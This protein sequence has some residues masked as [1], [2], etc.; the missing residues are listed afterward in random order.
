MTEWT[1]SHHA[2]YEIRPC[3]A[4]ST[5]R[6]IRRSQLVL[7]YEVG[8]VF[9]QVRFVPANEDAHGGKRNSERQGA[10]RHREFHWS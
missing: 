4:N 10:Q 3:A 9:T 1:Y 5:E 7:T 6:T 8:V 2:K